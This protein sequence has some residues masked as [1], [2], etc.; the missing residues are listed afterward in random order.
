MG[1]VTWY[2]AR[3]QEW[4]WP[5]PP[6]W[7]QASDGCWYPPPRSGTAAPPATESAGARLGRTFGAVPLW[8]RIAGPLAAAFVLLVGTG[9]LAE[10]EPEPAAEVSAQPTAPSTTTST[11]TST[12]APPTTLPPATVPTT[13]PPATMPP[14]PPPVTSPP[15]PAPEPEPEPPAPST[16]YANCTAARAAGPTPLYRGD[17]GYASHLD[18]DDDGVACE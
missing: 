14:P 2:D 12:T 13:L 3:G 5:P 8:A 15:E 11:T 9:A 7:W 1:S 10:D 6:G 16:Y 4:P 18:R 17:P